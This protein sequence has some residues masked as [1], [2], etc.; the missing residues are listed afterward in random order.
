VEDVEADRRIRVEIK[1][2]E[3]TPVEEDMSLPRTSHVKGRGFRER[4][5]TEPD[6]KEM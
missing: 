3:A 4:G 1:V 5:N 6:A 2:I